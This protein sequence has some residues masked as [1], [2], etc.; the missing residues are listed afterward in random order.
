[1]S[2]QQAQV[3]SS[4]PC[5]S[6]VIQ[7]HVNLPLP[8]QLSMTGNPATNWKRFKRAWNNYEIA[9][10]LKDTSH[11][12]ENKE[13]R[14][15]TLLTCIGSDALDVYDGFYLESQEQ[16]KDIDVTLQKFEQYCI[17]ETNESYER[18]V[19]R[20]DQ[21]QHVSVDAHTTALRTLAKTCNVGQLEDDLTRDRIV[22]G[23]R[24]DATG[25]KLLQV[26]KLIPLLSA[27][28]SADHMRK[29]QNN[30]YVMYNGPSD[31]Q[32]DALPSELFRQLQYLSRT[33]FDVCCPFQIAFYI[34]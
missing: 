1:M 29:H 34:S 7:I 33:Y 20:H 5:P 25:K 16:V 4:T 31:L 10:R 22:M 18:R 21:N 11:P 6:Q 27:L 17:G 14:T 3:E 9:T 24:D 8:S 32:S 28:T 26:E 15:A 19:N 30:W 12:E 13:L 23:I 2:D